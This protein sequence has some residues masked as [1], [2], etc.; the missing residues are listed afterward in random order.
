VTNIVQVTQIVEKEKLV[1]IKTGQNSQ[2]SAPCPVEFTMYNDRR[3]DFWKLL[4]AEV[5]AEEALYNAKLERQ[6]QRLKAT[7]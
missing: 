4:S 3:A 6:R 7:M 2:K 1:Y 5:Q